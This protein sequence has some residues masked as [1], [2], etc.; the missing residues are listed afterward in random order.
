MLM[1]GASRLLREMPEGYEKACY[2]TKAM[3]R[4]R[5]IKDPNDLMLLS[6]YHLLNGCSL[7]EVSAIS[8][9]TKIGDISDVAFMKRF[10][11]CSNW[12]KWV[13]DN[14]VSDGLIEY[15]IPETLRGYRIL[16]T[17]ASDV[18]EKGRAERYYRLHFALD[19]VKMHAA[20]YNIT[21]QNVGE[22]LRNFDFQKNDL[23]LADR[24]Y[25]TPTGIEYCEGR[26]VQY[27]LRMRVNSFTVYDAENR[28]LD[29]CSIIGQNECGS[30]YGYIKRENQTHKVRICYKRKDA[31]AIEATRKRL[32]RRESK[33]QC[34]IS[35][36]TKSF[37]EYIVVVTSLPDTISAKEILD[38]YRYRWQVE[39]Y[40][41]RLKSILNYGE[42]PKRTEASIF[43][44]LN[45][46]LMIALLIERMLSKDSFPP[47]AQSFEEYLE[48]D[49]DSDFAS[50]Q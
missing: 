2:T 20:Y 8:K 10:Q 24:I 17:D 9:L 46:K 1:I 43:S 12:F 21:T 42:L 11:K 35:E 6:L 41:K 23:V 37:N 31:E 14:T 49:E 48:G 34:T 15:D 36:R 16:A 45:G 38:L 50:C 7:M 39:L 13:I 27:V 29:V 40:F 5:D 33:N 28:K 19:I 18:T 30:F 25:S 26:N 22:S 4:R 32:H 3:I 47:E 44:W